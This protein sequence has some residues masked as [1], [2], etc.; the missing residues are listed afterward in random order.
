MAETYIKRGDRTHVLTERFREEGCE[1]QR[2]EMGACRRREEQ[3]LKRVWKRGQGS[4]A[5]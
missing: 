4:R 2:A 3:A 5:A 1:G